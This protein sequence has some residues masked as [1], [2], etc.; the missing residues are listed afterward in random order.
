MMPLVAL[1]SLLVQIQSVGSMRGDTGLRRYFALLG[2]VTFAMLGFV[3][4]PNYFDLFVM[5]SLVSVCCWLLV[6]HWWRRPE[7]VR[8][9]R[10]AFLITCIGDVSLLLA[11][12]LSFVKFA[13]NV[14]LLSPTPGQDVNDPLSFTVLSSEWPRAHVGAVAGVGVRTLVV[15]ALLLLVAAAFKSAQLPIQTWLADTTEAPAPAAALIQSATVATLGGF[16]SALS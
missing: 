2:L 16:P 6:G 14:A 7:S 11:V 10:K 1:I 8:A 5:W 4:S 12:V 15:T 9:A 3:A 13:A